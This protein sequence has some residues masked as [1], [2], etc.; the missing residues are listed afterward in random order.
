MT[1]NSVYSF[2][3]RDGS[4]NPVNASLVFLSEYLCLFSDG[5][6]T[7]QLLNTGQRTDASLS[8]AEWKAMETLSLEGLEKRSYTVLDSKL[9]EDSF[10]LGVLTMELLPPEHTS[11]VINHNTKPSVA[12]YS[13]HVIHLTKSICAA[14]NQS[15]SCVEKSIVAK[16]DLICSLRSSMVAEYWALSEQALIL[17]TDSS[18]VP[19]DKEVTEKPPVAESRPKPKPVE[20]VAAGEKVQKE[21]EVGG[22]E[23]GKGGGEEVGEGG[24]KE[25]G[26]VGEE[27]VGK[28]E[29]KGEVGGEEEGEGEPEA[30][31]GFGYHKDSYEW[32][33]SSADVTITVQLP[34]DATKQDVLC[35]IGVGD[36]VV[37]LVDG[38]T[39]ARGALFAQVD[40]DASSWTLQDHM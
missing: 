27:E 38:T 5:R 13:W 19:K 20:D 6:G 40:P 33:Q 32:T 15:S 16:T 37:G 28:G 18:L 29:G 24:G 22:E 4:D 39:F 23:V 35:T 30:H 25:V 31:H 34:A 14:L 21:G 36:V 17:I 12:V 8:T 1:I 26:E 11:S 10:S 3:G 7:L 9:Y 2:V